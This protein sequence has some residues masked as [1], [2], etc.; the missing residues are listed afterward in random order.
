MEEARDTPM[1]VANL[2]DP[3]TRWWDVD[4][5]RNFFDV[6]SIELIKRIPIRQFP[7]MQQMIE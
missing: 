2:I 3:L 1:I 5:L 4:K 7:C 6:E